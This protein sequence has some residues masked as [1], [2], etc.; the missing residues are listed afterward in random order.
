M[1]I[2]LNFFWWFVPFQ[3]VIQ[4]YGSGWPFNCGSTLVSIPGT[5]G[6]RPG[7]QRRC[8]LPK[9]A[10]SCRPAPP[11]RRGRRRWTSR[12]DLHNFRRKQYRV[13]VH[14]TQCSGSIFQILTCLWKKVKIQTGD[15]R[16]RKILEGG[17]GSAQK[18][19]QTAKK[20]SDC[21]SVYRCPVP[22]SP[23]SIGKNEVDTVENEVDI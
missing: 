18:H 12:S 10:C 13:W 5:P 14:T 21:H 16:E 15:V 1:N 7:S 17:G 20:D 4:K 3:S 23:K 9:P 19:V 6:G 8:R 22:T 2:F 11:F